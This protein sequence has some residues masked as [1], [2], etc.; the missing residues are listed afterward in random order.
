MGSTRKSFTPE[1]RANAVSLVIDDHRTIADVARGIGMKPQTLG[2][3]VQKARDEQP[4]KTGL[5]PEDRIELEQL[6]KQ[7]SEL[8]MENEFLK[9][10]TAWFARNQR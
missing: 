5:D 7:N 2:K 4:E 10:V 8:R 1:Y 3:W 6:R 9:K